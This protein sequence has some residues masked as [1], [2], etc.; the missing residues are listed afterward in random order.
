MGTQSLSGRVGSVLHRGA[1]SEQLRTHRE[2]LSTGLGLQ[3]GDA[4]THTAQLPKGKVL[5][6][7]RC[8]LRALLSRWEDQLCC[9]SSPHWCAAFLTL[10]S[11]LGASDCPVPL[12]IVFSIT[13][14]VFQIFFLFFLPH[15]LFLLLFLKSFFFFSFP[16]D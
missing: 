12:L 1:G 14:L 8:S 4:H 5:S 10:L 9:S 11:L 7:S 16:A 15:F 6:L 2:G 3:P 13:V